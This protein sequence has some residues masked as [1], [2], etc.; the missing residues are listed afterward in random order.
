MG[1]RAFR[2]NDVIDQQ[3]RSQTEPIPAATRN[4]HLDNATSGATFTRTVQP[5]PEQDT[6]HPA[7]LSRPVEDWEGCPP[8]ARARN[9]GLDDPRAV[10]P[11]SHCNFGDRSIRACRA[12]AATQRKSRKRAV[13]CPGIV[14]H[15]RPGQANPADVTGQSATGVDGPRTTAAAIGRAGGDQRG[16]GVAGRGFPRPR[17]PWIFRRY[18]RP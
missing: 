4:V 12:T 17:V 2:R 7:P 16:G 13:P 15:P 8:L 5:S 1:R 10:R 11:D 9:L 14:R 18:P 6:Q 3:S